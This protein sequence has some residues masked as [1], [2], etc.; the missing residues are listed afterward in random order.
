MDAYLNKPNWGAG[1]GRAF[2]ETCREIRVELVIL[3]DIKKFLSVLGIWFCDSVG[4]PSF[5]F[6]SPFQS[7]IWKY[8][9]AK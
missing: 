2:F 8:L 5:H 6:S 1:E 9:G 4:R 3:G 7:Y